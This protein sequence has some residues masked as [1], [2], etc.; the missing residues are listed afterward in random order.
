MEQLSQAVELLNSGQLNQ[1]TQMLETLL[2]QKGED[3]D[4]YYYLARAAFLKDLHETAIDYLEK[5]IAL[6]D[7]RAEYHELLGEALGLK[8]QQA[9]MIKGAMLIRKVKAAFEKAIELNENSLAAREGLFMIYLFMPPVAGG[10]EKQAM[11]LLEEIKNLS[12]VHG[13]LAQ[14]LAY[15]RQQRFDDVEKEFEQAVAKNGQDSEILMRVGRFYM[16]RKNYEKAGEVCD[17]YIENRP[18]DPRGYQLKGEVFRKIGDLQEAL[19]WFNLAIEKD[20]QN[21]NALYHRAL[22]FKDLN[23]VEKAREDLQ[24]I[25]AFPQKHPLKD[26]AKKLLKEF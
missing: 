24:K 25:I 18:A 11:R 17:V 9:G 10:D 5:A 7:Q 22:T 6:N 1:A 13:H 14:G 3:P 8:A 2:Q 26:R 21:L 20:P 4:V 15:I 12:E 19:N 23:Q 16:E